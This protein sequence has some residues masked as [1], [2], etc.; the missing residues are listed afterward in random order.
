MKRI[1]KILLIAIPVLIAIFLVIVA[2][3][4]S[5]FRVVRS[6]TIAAPPEAV[7]PHVNELKKWDAWSPWAKLDPNAKSTF[8][9]PEAGTGAVMTW[10]GNNDVGEGRMTITEIR[11]NELVQFKL[12]FYKPMAGTC[13]AEF[14]FKPEGNQTTVTWSMSGQNNFMA[15]AVGLFMDCDAMVGGQFEQ[16]LANLKSATEGAK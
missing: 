14:A 9:G 3:Q 15:K 4:P 12:E 11:P 2:M 6:T 8:E 10:A 5:D 13:T 1:L 7:F 16:G